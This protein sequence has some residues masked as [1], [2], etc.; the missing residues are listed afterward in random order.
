MVRGPPSR[1]VLANQFSFRE[2]RCQ[3]KDPLTHAYCSRPAFIKCSHCGKFLCLKHFIERVCF[4]ETNEELAGP[5]GTH[6]HSIVSE[7]DDDDFDPDLFR[8][9]CARPAATGSA[10]RSTEH[11]ELRAKIN[12]SRLISRKRFGGRIS[13]YHIRF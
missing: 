12:R 5:S 6:Q 11:D 3:N 4:H 9:P 13:D 2:T 1:G 7:E 8:R 10:N